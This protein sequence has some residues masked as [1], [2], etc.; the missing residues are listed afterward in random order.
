[1]DRGRNHPTHWLLPVAT[2]VLFVGMARRWR[3]VVA[4]ESMAPAFRPG[5]RLLLLPSR[6]VEPGDVLA[7]RDPRNPSRLLIKRVI[8]R[9]GD[10][11]DVRGDHEAASTDSRHFGPVP[12]TAVAGRVVYRYSPAAS[13]GRVRRRR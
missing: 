11:L 4:G 13:A 3:I 5:D 10:L 6:R 1:M 8:R 9:D 12:V 7:V 2:A